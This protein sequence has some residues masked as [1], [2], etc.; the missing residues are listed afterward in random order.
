MPGLY[1]TDETRQGWGPEMLER[2]SISGMVDCGGYISRGYGGGDAAASE[3][4]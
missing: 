3:A 4:L 2:P 1:L